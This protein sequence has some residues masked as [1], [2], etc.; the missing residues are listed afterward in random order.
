ME[1][2]EENAGGNRNADDVIEECPEQVLLDVLESL[3][4]ELDSSR[5]IAQIRAHQNDGAG[6]D[7]DVA[8]AAY[9]NA[10]I[11]LGESGS[12]VNAV[13]DHHNFMALF[14]ETFDHR[15]LIIR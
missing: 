11:G 12:I 5:Y 8:A 1:E 2:G 9:G 10:D 6:F 3:M 4:A 15:C 13:A 7:C 14:L